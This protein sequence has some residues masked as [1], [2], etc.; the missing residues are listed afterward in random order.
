MRSHSD[1]LRTEVVTSLFLAASVVAPLYFSP[2]HVRGFAVFVPACAY[3]QKSLVTLLESEELL[4]I[5][6]ENLT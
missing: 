5:I 3:R 4:V 2:D 6:G 1:I